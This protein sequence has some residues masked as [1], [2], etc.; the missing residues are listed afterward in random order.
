MVPNGR[1]NEGPIEGRKSATASPVVRESLRKPQPMVIPLGNALANSS[2]NMSDPD[3]NI[4]VS[5]RIPL[6]GSFTVPRITSIEQVSVQPLA[7]VTITSYSPEAS[8][9]MI[10]VADASPF[11][12]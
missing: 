4:C 6:Q 9:G 2:S 12:S 3:Q 8:T 11:H 10:D 7:S 1:R 5:V